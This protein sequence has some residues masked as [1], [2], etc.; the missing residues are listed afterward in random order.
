MKHKI[1]SIDTLRENRVEGIAG[2]IFLML[3]YSSRWFGVSPEA[4][5]F[6]EIL[7]VLLPLTVIMI[8]VSLTELIDTGLDKY[9]E[10][11]K[12][13][14]TPIL[15]AVTEIRPTEFQI[16]EAI[17]VIRKQ[18]AALHEAHHLLLT[19][20]NLDDPHERFAKDV[21]RDATEKIK[22]IEQ[23]RVQLS[24]EAFFDRLR[25]EFMA[26]QSG[27]SVLAVNAFETTRWTVD[28]RETIY[29]AEN[30]KAIERGAS[31]E[32]IFILSRN[33]ENEDDAVARANVLQDHIDIHVKVFIVYRDKLRGR[34]ELMK[35]VIMFRGVP[36]CLYE[37]FED[38]IDTMRISHGELHLGKEAHDNF[39]EHYRQL[40][41]FTRE[42]ELESLLKKYVPKQ[43][44]NASGDES[45]K[46]TDN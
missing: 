7:S 34:H 5:S 30:K 20:T 1:L 18:N 15:A 43:F 4:A 44:H 19:I 40:K 41:A 36:Q 28:P 35:D 38:T 14:T 26:L 31:V 39:F 3:S 8:K 16:L 24:P 6:A 23:D 29:F 10:E 12:M 22:L 45:K 2:I 25:D 46:I 42:D 37:D 33:P 21:I 32:R 11:I 9:E 13:A 17:S 27:D